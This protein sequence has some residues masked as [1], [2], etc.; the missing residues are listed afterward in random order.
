MSQN[1]CLYSELGVSKAATVDEI[2]A[3]F[4]KLA[5]THHPDRHVDLTEAQQTIESD[6]FKRISSAYQ[7]LLTH[8]FPFEIE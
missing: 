8:F 6:R 7:V 2:K 1:K 3:A 5:L 4:R